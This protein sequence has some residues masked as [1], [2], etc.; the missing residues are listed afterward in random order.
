MEGPSTVDNCRGAP[1]TLEEVSPMKRHNKP[2]MFRQDNSKVFFF[3]SCLEGHAPD[4]YL[5]EPDRTA[6]RTRSDR[7]STELTV[8]FAQKTEMH[9]KHDSLD[10]NRSVLQKSVEF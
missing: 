3:N 7:E 5:L 9:S 6:G 4:S 2:T 1:I 8:W 10:V